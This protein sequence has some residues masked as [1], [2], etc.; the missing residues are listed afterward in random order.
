MLR[1]CVVLQVQEQIKW[2]SVPVYSQLSSVS[3]LLCTSSAGTIGNAMPV[4]HA[5]EDRRHSVDSIP[6]HAESSLQSSFMHTIAWDS[7]CPNNQYQPGHAYML[8]RRQDRK[9]G[10]GEWEGLSSA[11]LVCAFRVEGFCFCSRSL[12]LERGRLPLLLE[13]GSSRPGSALLR[14][15]A[16][17]WA[18]L[19][20]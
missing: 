17:F 14:G 9:G 7:T 6:N 2:F 4:E 19:C 12:F 8:R 3:L 11:S 10:D 20:S 15:S 16:D 5:T 18:M 13:F 1:C